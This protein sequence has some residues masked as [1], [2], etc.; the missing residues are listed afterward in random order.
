MQIYDFFLIVR[1]YFISD[2]GFMISGPLA[3]VI[4][5]K[6]T[7]DGTDL[8][9]ATPDGGSICIRRFRLQGLTP[10]AYIITP[11][12]GFRCASPSP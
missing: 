6:T 5:V 8:H 2:F 12:R 3:V 11:L 4:Y 1:S 9:Y 10:P 7:T